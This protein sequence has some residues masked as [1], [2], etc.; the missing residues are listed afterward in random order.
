MQSEINPDAA[1]GE[2]VKCFINASQNSYSSRSKSHSGH[3]GPTPMSNDDRRRGGG[4]G[5]RRRGFLRPI[6][7]RYEQLPDCRPP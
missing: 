5:R 1:E 7:Q 3:V 6:V 4:R 2:E